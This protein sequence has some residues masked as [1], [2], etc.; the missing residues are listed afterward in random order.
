[1]KNEENFAATQYRRIVVLDIETV[2]LDPVNA[3]GALD[4]LTGRIV[5][6]GLLFD[7]G[8][9][10]V[11]QALLEEDEPNL[12]VKIWGSLK[13][14]D[15]I[16]GHNVLEFD[17]PFIRQR[18]WIQN[19]RPSRPI[20]L[21]KFYTVDVVDTMQLWTNWG[22][23][24]GVSLDDLAQALGVGQKTG[25]GTDVAHWWAARDFQ[26]IKTY[27][28]EDVRLTHRIYQRLTYQSPINTLPASVAGPSAAAA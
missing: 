1:M 16:V 20:D 9:T 27:C 12:L 19:I 17:M 18:S 23:K 5:C 21:R 14:T 8:K 2:T 3:K 11:E 13:P 24:K 22:F 7:D 10:L 25:H 26:S 28:M 6:A 4:A 15:A